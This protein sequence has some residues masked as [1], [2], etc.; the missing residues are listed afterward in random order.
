MNCPK[1][2]SSAVTAAKTS[3]PTSQIHHTYL[4]LT[5]LNCGNKFDLTEHSESRS[6]KNEVKEAEKLEEKGIE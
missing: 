2:K 1:C 3:I 5:C 6:N 4:T